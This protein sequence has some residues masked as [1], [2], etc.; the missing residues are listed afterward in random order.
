MTRMAAGPATPV[1][2]VDSSGNPI[3]TQTV[4]GTVTA[5]AEQYSTVKSGELAGSAS[6]V[7]MPDVACK[8][9]RFKAEAGNAGKVYIGA[10]GVT[11]PDGTTDATT[12]LQLLA[13]DDTGWIPT[14]NLNRFYRISDN[15]GDDLTYLAMV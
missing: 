10:S 7:Q 13:G 12:G 2:L 15:A 11:R 4:S 1:Y 8:L 14:D 6:A 5:R 3:S 9:V